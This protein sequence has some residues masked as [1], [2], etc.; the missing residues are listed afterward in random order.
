M[1]NKKVILI[2]SEDRNYRLDKR[3]ATN[4]QNPIKFK[5]EDIIYTYIVY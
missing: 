1:I 5:E 2:D 3:K 4:I